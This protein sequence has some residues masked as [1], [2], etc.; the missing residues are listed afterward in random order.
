MAGCRVLAIVVVV[1][2]VPFFVARADDD[3]A[4]RTRR[5]RFTYAAE[6][7]DVPAQ[8]REAT[9]WLPVPPNNE[10]QE[11]SNIVVRSDVPTTVNREEEYGNQVLSLT[12]RN[13]GSRPLRLEL[14]FDVVRR[15][16]R[17]AAA[18]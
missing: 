6:G 15:E 2:N 13:P 5:V 11:S 14:Q 3:P 18:D 10:S 8:D 16:R 12:A 4:P 17:N 7:P 1:A 9:V